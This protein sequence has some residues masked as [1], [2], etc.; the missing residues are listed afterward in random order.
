MTKREN[1]NEYMRLYM[2]DRYKRLRAACIEAL[3][4]QCERC[5][6][7]EKLQFHHRDRTLKKFTI[8]K[9]LVSVARDQ[10]IIE[11]AKC[12]LLCEMCHRDETLKQ[13]GRELG[14]GKHGLPS[15]YRYCR[16][17]LCKQAWSTYCKQRRLARV[18]SG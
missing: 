3:G 2:L 6:S 15:S 4:G 10:L 13:L 7:K 9:R 12:G 14:K 18:A 5:G 11:L 1:Y 8:A 17:E 16:C